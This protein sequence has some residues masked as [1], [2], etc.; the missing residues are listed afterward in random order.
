MATA[1]G[2]TVSAYSNSAPDNP[3]DD[4]ETVLGT[5]T[6]ITTTDVS[7]Q[8]WVHAQCQVGADADATSIEFRLRAGIDATGDQLG[9]VGYSDSLPAGDGNPLF[10]DFLVDLGPNVQGEAVTLTI[11]LPG[12]TDVSGVGNLVIIATVF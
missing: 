4:T 1:W 7:R 2:P 11:A 5:I 6:G 10:A 9:E 8:L 12:A 3:P